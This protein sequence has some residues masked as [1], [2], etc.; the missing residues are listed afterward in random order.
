MVNKES[1][2]LRFSKVLGVSDNRVMGDWTAKYG[3]K[4]I[5]AVTCLAS[6]CDWSAIPVT[7]LYR[8]YKC[9]KGVTSPLLVCQTVYNVEVLTCKIRIGRLIIL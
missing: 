4:L 5:V 3:I 1:K 7:I 2:Y 6:V 9:R 8:N